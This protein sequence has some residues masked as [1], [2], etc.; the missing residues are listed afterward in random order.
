MNVC[1]PCSHQLHHSISLNLGMLFGHPESHNLMTVLRLVAL[2]PS[3]I[4][5]MCPYL[6]LK[7]CLNFVQ[8]GT[9]RDLAVVLEVL[10]SAFNQ[11]MCISECMRTECNKPT[12]TPDVDD[13]VIMVYTAWDLLLIFSGSHL[14]RQHN[15][16][17]VAPKVLAST[18]LA[19]VAG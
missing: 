6:S 3:Y 9:C 1:G 2:D 4:H 17:R 8:R 11:R 15:R 10:F 12:M 5:V 18:Q 19:C 14:G 13:L 16:L 7:V